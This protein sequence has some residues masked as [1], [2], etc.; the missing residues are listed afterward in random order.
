MDELYKSTPDILDSEAE[1]YEDSVS[2]ILNDGS[3]IDAVAGITD[4]NE[5]E[6]L[7]E[8]EPEAIEEDPEVVAAAQEVEAL[9]VGEYADYDIQALDEP[10]PEEPAESEAPEEEDDIP[11]DLFPDEVQGAQ[12]EVEDECPDGEPCVRPAKILSAEEE[13]DIPYEILDDE[14]EED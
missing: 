8:E 6:I 14:D 13:E 7:A 9:D 4:E 12:D 1:E 3:D 11:A 2:E 10:E 5:D